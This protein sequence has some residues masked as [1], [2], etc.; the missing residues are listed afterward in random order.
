MYADV[1]G[2]VVVWEEIS[3]L[4]CYLSTS[5]QRPTNRHVLTE[6]VLAGFMLTLLRICAHV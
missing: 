5:E 1:Y 6:M 4:G 3:S 2:W